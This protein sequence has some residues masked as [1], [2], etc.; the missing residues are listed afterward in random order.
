HR[1]DDFNGQNQEGVGYYQLTTHRGWRASAAQAYLKPA[2]RRPNLSIF[3]DAQ[4]TKVLFDGK[5]AV[6][7]RYRQG[8]ADREP[9]A[10]QGVI[11]CAGAIQSPQLLMLSGIGDADQLSG[12]GIKPLIDRAEVGTNLQ[13][14]LQFRLIYRCSKPIT[15]NDELNSL[16]GRIRIGLQWLLSR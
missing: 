7:V 14:H 3:T 5:R 4:A 13:D 6:G 16:T 1:T 2:R 10:G 9:K 11:L 15:T 8:G 12:M